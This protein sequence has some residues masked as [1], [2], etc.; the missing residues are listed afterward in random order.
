[1]S[2][3]RRW[4]RP[5]AAAAGSDARD[6]IPSSARGTV[7]TRSRASR[8]IPK[9]R[10]QT[11]W[12]NR[13]RGPERCGGRSPAASAAGPAQPTGPSSGQCPRPRANRAGTCWARSAVPRTGC[14]PRPS[15]TPENNPTYPSRPCGASSEAMGATA[16]VTRAAP[17]RN[18]RC[19]PSQ[20]RPPSRSGPGRRTRPGCGRRRRPAGTCL[21]PGPPERPGKPPP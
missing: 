1:M 11:I 13:A 6:T 16:P 7:G 21:T 9:F 12:R 19:R 17:R 8:S 14:P 10:P 4:Y 2:R 3:F 18:R 20:T 15:R 5:D